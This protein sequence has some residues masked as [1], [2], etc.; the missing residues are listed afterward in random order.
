MKFD[1]SKKFGFIKGRFGEAVAEELLTAL[2]WEVQQ[3]GIERSFPEL[4]STIRVSGK[5]FKSI[6]AIQQI[7]ALPD[8]LVVRNDDRVF[9]ECK[10]RTDGKPDQREIK[11]YK[12]FGSDVVILLISPSGIHAGRVSSILARGTDGY[13]AIESFTDLVSED[14]VNIACEFSALAHH[15]FDPIPKHKDVL[16]RIA[17]DISQTVS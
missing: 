4:A 9:I 6:V 5:D 13:Q 8:F 7:R 16:E 1:I 14:K 12:D 3:L 17:D 11:M 15:V 10:Y 2:G